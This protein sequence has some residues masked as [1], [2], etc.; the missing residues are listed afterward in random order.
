M[1]IYQSQKEKGAFFKFGQVLIDN[2]KDY[3][4]YTS[5]IAEQYKTGDFVFRGVPEAK[6][7]LFNS[8]QRVWRDIADEGSLK[9]EDAYDAFIVD[10]MTE[11]RKWNIETIPNFLNTYGISK[12]NSIAYLSF[13]QHYGIPTPLMDFTRNP[14]KALFFATEGANAS[15][16]SEVVLD[17]YISLY[18]TYQNNTAYESFAA[19]FSKNSK[20]SAEGE[21]DYADITK[22]GIVLASERTKEFKIINNIRI[23]N[24]E[25]LFFYNNSPF[26]PIEVLYKEFADLSLE[27]FG[28]RKFD[29]LLMHETF[30]GCLNIH[31][32]Y[33]P[34]IQHTLK[35]MNITKEFV[36]PNVDDLLGHCRAAYARHGKS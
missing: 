15:S 33:T 17:N 10:L 30:C 13:M 29:E 5:L 8:A 32:K 26:K 16:K 22:N 19:V 34:H 28:R 23:A 20:T 36:Y 21:F 9:N 24:Q 27:K 18:F 31:K 3:Y 6:Y 7:K 4:Y 12:K 2:D 14:Y 11:C 1:E 35:K 25:G